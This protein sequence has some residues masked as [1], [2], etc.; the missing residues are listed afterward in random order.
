MAAEAGHGGGVGGEQGQGLFE[1]R[2]GELDEVSQGAVEREQAAGEDSADGGAAAGDLYGEAAELVFAV[3]HSS[4]AHGVCDEN[5][6]GRPFGAG[7]QPDQFGSDVDA[8]ADELGK[9]GI[10]GKHDAED[11][12]FA[13][14]E[15]T[16]GV[17]GVGCADCS[18]SDSSAGLGGGGVGV[19]EGDADAARGG[20]S[21]ELGGS[22]QLGCQRHE[23]YL[24]LG[25]LEEP[26][27]DGDVGSEKVLWRVDAA[28][29]VREKRPLKM[30]PNG[31]GPIFGGRLRDELCQARES[32]QS[33][34]EGC[35][36]GC[37]E[38]AA[39]AVL[40]KEA[41]NSA[42]SL[43]R[44]FHHVVA[45]CAVD[46]HVE[47]CRSQGRAGIVENARVGGDF[48]VVAGGDGGDLAVF[49]NDHGAVE[50]GSSV[51]EL[52]G[53]EHRAHTVDYC[54]GPGNSSCAP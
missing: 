44:S 38:I 3:G 43:G 33:G 1:R 40:G 53:S 13:M 7:P 14:V 5:G 41:A 26:I 52:P 35:G 9:K 16:H 49:D 27:K 48:G 18:G 23:A 47:E 29:G 36:H 32:A 37:G 34:I 46:M 20:V 19:A 39:G 12:G 50:E 45:G 42:E 28:L 22:G 25:G 54:R 6:A 11:A 4:R 24:A 10:G 31:L 8:V 51:P 15:G 21:C 2:A 17:E 30:N